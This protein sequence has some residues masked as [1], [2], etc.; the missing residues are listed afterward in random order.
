[1][2]KIHSTNGH[3]YIASSCTRDHHVAGCLGA[4]ALP[5][6]KSAPCVVDGGRCPVSRGEVQGDR[7]AVTGD[8]IVEH[9]A[10]CCRALQLTH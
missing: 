2:S 5:A 1:M 10:A 7:H 9:A 6:V 8:A 4:A 3:A